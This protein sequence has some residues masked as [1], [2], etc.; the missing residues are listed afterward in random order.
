MHQIFLFIEQ[1]HQ[2]IRTISRFEAALI[3]SMRP[4]ALTSQEY[5]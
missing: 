5:A 1:L 4:V 3:A 2:S